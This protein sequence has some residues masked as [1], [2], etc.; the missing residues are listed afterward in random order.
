MSGPPESAKP[1]PPG[2]PLTA[3]QAARE[4]VDAAFD[5]ALAGGDFTG[6]FTALGMTQGTDR[7]RP[8]T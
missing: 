1:K 5:N 2:N 6:S 8:E 4:R 3:D 7:A